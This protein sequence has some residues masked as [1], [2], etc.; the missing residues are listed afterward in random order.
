MNRYVI[1][2][3]RERKK[4][5]RPYRLE[6]TLGIPYYVVLVSLIVIP[7]LMMALY[8]FQTERPSGVFTISFTLEHYVSFFQEGLF[9]RLMIES[10]YL[11]FLATLLTLVIGYPLA[12]YISMSKPRTRV[13]LILLISAPMW[14]NM[15]LRTRALQQVFEMVA[16]NLLGTNLAIV[17]GMTYI[18]L[19]FMVLP[20]YTVLSKID[21]ALYESSADLGATRLQTIVR[22][23]IP[24]S[25]SG[26]LSGIMMVFLP[27]ATTLVVPKYLGQ[28]RYLVGNLIENAMIQQGRFGYGSAIA[29][30][31]ALLIMAS[32]YMI[33][34]VD[35]YQGGGELEAE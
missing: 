33:K 32:L 9:V 14:I 35:K 21:P 20:I 31:L 12:Y 1:F 29:I 25:L 6:R 22:V 24:L 3:P 16:P 15:L 17:I 18:F 8:S 13:L 30:I 4:R 27:A 23:I 26:I 2:K 34:R 19:P 5:T 10:L 7:I 28:G 11:A